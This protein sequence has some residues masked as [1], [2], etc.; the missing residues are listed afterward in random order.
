MITLK[1]LLSGN[2]FNSQTPEIQRSLM[3][4]LTK[5]SQIRTAYNDIMD[6]S[7]GLRT[8][9]HHLEIYAAKGIVDQ[10]KI[11]MKSKHLFG[12]AVD[13]RD[14]AGKLQQWCRDNQALLLSIGVWMEDFSKTPGW[15]HFQS[16]AYAS[17]K[18]GKS[19]WFIP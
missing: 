10:S 8:M 14:P 4:L 12:Q 17:W 6:V 2:D 16:V 3:D 1:E 19:L 11:P 13:I 15:V 7:S 5:V 18:P 9:K